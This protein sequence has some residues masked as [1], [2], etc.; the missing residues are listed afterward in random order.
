MGYRW[1]TCPDLQG[2]E[3]NKRGAK[4]LFAGAYRFV[5]VGRLAPIYRGLKQ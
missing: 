2:I 1:T 3:T 5:A 4:L